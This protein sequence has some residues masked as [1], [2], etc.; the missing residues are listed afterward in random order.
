MVIASGRDLLSYITWSLQITLFFYQSVY[1]FYS[2]QKKPKGSNVL[3]VRVLERT[4]LLLHVSNLN[5][6]LCA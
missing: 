3:K 1:I 4:A 6:W 2:R 5:C